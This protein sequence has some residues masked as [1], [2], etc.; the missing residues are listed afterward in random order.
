MTRG[1]KSPDDHQGERN[2][3]DKRRTLV[4]A[5]KEG[6]SQYSNTLLVEGNGTLGGVMGDG[7]EVRA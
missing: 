3:L 7:S 6:A 1:K 2:L 4:L 5:R